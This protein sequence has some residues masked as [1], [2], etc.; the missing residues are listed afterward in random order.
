M[1]AIA[2]TTSD[3]GAFTLMEESDPSFLVGSGFWSPSLPNNLL[4]L[5]NNHDMRQSWSNAV[6]S[7]TPMPRLGSTIHTS[8]PSQPSRLEPPPYQPF[9]RDVISPFTTPMTPTTTHRP[10]SAQLVQRNPSHLDLPNFPLPRPY[11]DVS[12][13]ERQDEDNFPLY[14]LSP[15][16]LPNFDSQPS[17]ALA[18]IS[19]PVSRLSWASAA[20]STFEFP[21]WPL[22][23]SHEGFIDLTADPSPPGVSASSRKRP[24]ST[25]HASTR[26][27][28][29]PSAS[30]KRKKREEVVKM[31]RG[32]VEEVDLR[33]VDDDDGLSK[34]LE[35]QR[36]V[37]IKAQQE[38]ADKPVNF[39]SLQCIICMESITDITVTHCGHVFCHACL[40]EA[41]IAG[42]QQGP[43]TGLGVGKGISKCPVCRKK[44]T[45][46]KDNKPSL[47]VIPLEIKMM[48]RSAIEKRKRKSDDGT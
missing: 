20:S 34:V 41:L 37:S 5:E 45:R 17:N 18:P 40:M 9:A 10:P 14:D 13:P 4:P 28:V 43:E 26:D 12:N 23:Q 38:L 21:S 47:Q 27:S 19:R 3:Q 33:E 44:V 36:I 25:L 29:T 11:H 30:I 1:T 2:T 8:T 22:S 24:A 42:E 35:Q 6:Q 31:E 7:G 48:S 32:G 15:L 16:Q 46:P 39:S